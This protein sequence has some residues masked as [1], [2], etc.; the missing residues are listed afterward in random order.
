MSWRQ[1][2]YHRYKTLHACAE[3]DGGHVELMMEVR[4]GHEIQRLINDEL[5]T[6]S[7]D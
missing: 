2:Y 5:P 4:A 6:Q 3:P 1:P 7:L